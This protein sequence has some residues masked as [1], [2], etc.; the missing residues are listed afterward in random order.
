VTVDQY[1]K[2]K[3]NIVFN[4]DFLFAVDSLPDGKPNWVP[5]STPDFIVTTSNTATDSSKDL[6]PGDLDQ[7]P[8]PYPTAVVPLRVAGGLL[9]L[10][11]LGWLVWAVYRRI[12]PPK[13][14]PA[15]EVAWNTFD[16]VLSASEAG[17]GV[18]YERTQQIAHALR[19]YL[20]V[21]SVPLA[22]VEGSLESFFANDTDKRYENTRVA[23]EALAIL[24][25]ALYE[26]PADETRTPV[27][28]PRDTRDLFA[29]I[30]RI[31]PRP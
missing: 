3:N 21:E 17:V 26:K 27:L 5:A 23:L 19:V 20:Q 31:V 15:N 14:L 9:L 7:K 12:N 11:P 2:P 6:L 22:E 1:G 4:T 13:V 16:R 28:S 25:K 18:T 29:R 24:D 8:Y 10:F 30:E